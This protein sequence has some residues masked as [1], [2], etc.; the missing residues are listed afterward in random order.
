[1]DALRCVVI[2]LVVSDNVVEKNVTGVRHLFR[3]YLMTVTIGSI[4]ARFLPST[5]S[6][7]RRSLVAMK[8]MSAIDEHENEG[9]A[10]ACWSVP[11]R[12]CGPINKCFKESG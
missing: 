10:V 1:L 6:A 2:F 12:G 8:M 4:N 3:K 5:K 9:T 11:R 7:I